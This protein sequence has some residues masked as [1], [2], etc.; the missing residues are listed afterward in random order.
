MTRL[1][2][3]FENLTTSRP[4]FATRQSDAELIVDWSWQ[5]AVRGTVTLAANG[6]PLVAFEPGHAPAPITGERLRAEWWR[7]DA[8]R[9]TSIA[10]ASFERAAEA[11]RHRVHRHHERQVRADAAIAVEVADDRSRR[12]GHR[13]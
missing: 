11:L 4:T 7:V 9:D 10:D 12:S 5:R 1:P 2:F 13:P 8:A 3:I 6:E